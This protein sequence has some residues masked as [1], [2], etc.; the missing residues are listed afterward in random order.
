M[1][2]ILLVALR[3]GKAAGRDLQTSKA[4]GFGGAADAGDGFFV[5]LGI[6]HDAAFADVGALQFKLRLD[7]DEK[8]AAGFT[9]GD[10]TGKNFGDRDKRNINNDEFNVF[11]KIA[12]RQFAGVLLED[13]HAWL[14]AQLPGELVGVD[15]HRVDARR[16]LLQ[17]AISEAARGGTHVEA[18]FPLRVDVEIFQR[19]FELEAAAA[20][21][22]LQAAVN[23]DWRVFGDRLA[24]FFGA[25]G[26]DCD[27]ARQD[28]GLRFLA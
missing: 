24:S 28:H 17:Q 5:Q 7:E 26:V 16:A 2:E 11:R 1:K 27:F 8:L 9:A 6:A 25:L 21:V 4:M 14:F 13:N 23:F 20:G 12:G 15:V 19:A 3:A 10:G 18:D 22:F